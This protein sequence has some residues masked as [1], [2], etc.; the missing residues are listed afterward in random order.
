MSCLLAVLFLSLSSYYISKILSEPQTAMTLRYGMGFAM[1]V[2][3]YMGVLRLLLAISGFPKW[4]I[5]GATAAVV[6]IQGARVLMSILGPAELA[7]RFRLPALLLISCYL[8]FLGLVLYRAARGSEDGTVAFILKGLGSLTLLFAP[9][10]FLIY[11][12]LD[13]LP[14]AGTLGVSLD[15]LFILVWNPV[16]Q[17]LMR[18]LVVVK[19][20]I[21]THSP[22]SN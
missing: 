17:A 4:T 18:P 6:A 20:R 19:W 8:F 10:S 13:L 15:F 22:S 7:A 9:L 14:G 12:G 11:L 21:S 2:V 16:S 1:T 3:L 5:I